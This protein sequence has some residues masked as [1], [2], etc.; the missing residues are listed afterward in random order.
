MMAYQKVTPFVLN[1]K[2]VRGV[3]KGEL[4]P[5]NSHKSGRIAKMHKNAYTNHLERD[6]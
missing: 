1:G 4:D 3:G 2:S 5:S 6:G